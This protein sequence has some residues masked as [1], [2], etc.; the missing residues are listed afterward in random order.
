MCQT[1]KWEWECIHKMKNIEKLLPSFMKL[2]CKCKIAFVA[3]FKKKIIKSS[4]N[5]KKLNHDLF[6]SI[7][8]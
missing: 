7:R 8:L 6:N 5:T 3:T 4:R 1:A 2:V